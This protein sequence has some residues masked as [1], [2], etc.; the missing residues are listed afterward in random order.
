MRALI[1][2]DSPSAREQARAALEDAMGEL[3]LSFQITLAGN[4]V[5]ALK[6]LASQDVRLLVV[7][8]HMPDIH[9]LEVLSFWSKRPASGPRRALV[10]TTEVS[11]R[12]RAKVMDAGASRFLEKPCSS[13]AMLEALADFAV[14]A[15]A[16]AAKGGR[17]AS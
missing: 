17:G 14:E 6:V 8:L 16:E 9:G 7:D 4:G 11:A 10:V 3:G 15:K 5:E 12:D 1:V 13:S 2:D